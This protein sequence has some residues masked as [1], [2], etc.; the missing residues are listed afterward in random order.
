MFEAPDLMEKS[1]REVYHKKPPVLASIPIERKN[2]LER[3]LSVL[4]EVRPGEG[5]GVLLLTANIFVLLAGYYLLKTAREALIL[6]EGGAEVKTYSSAAQALLLWCVVPAY[7]AL[8]SRMGRLRVITAITLIFISNLL[9]FWYFGAQGKREGVV[10]F[11]WVGIFN[12][13]AVAQFWSFANDLFSEEQGKRLFPIIGIGSSTGALAGAEVASPFIKKAGPYPLMLAAAGALAVCLL[14]T[15]AIHRR[16]EK[17]PAQFSSGPA[18]KPLSRTNGL[19][20]ILRD[21]YLLLIAALIVLLNVVNTSGEFLLG[22]FVVAEAGRTMGPNLAAQQK[23]IGEF[24]GHFFSWVNL[25]GVLVQMFGVSRIFRHIGVRGSLYILPTIAAM[26]YC[27]LLFL[28]ILAVIRVGKILE[29]STD[30]SIMNTTRHA[31]FLPTSREAK[32][33]AKSAVDTFFPRSGDVLQ[34]GIVYAGTALAI[35]ISG[36]AIL[37]LV[38]TAAWLGVVV[39]LRR[40]HV[41]ASAAAVSA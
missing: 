23:F 16:V 26:N 13:F 22:K 41:R 27:L 37:N 38:L 36:F 31:L 21:R 39:A 6:S 18:D 19:Q 1:S 32:Y 20:L 14:L 25:V 10:F 2:P 40:Q 34:A 24:Y 9:L 4:A 8:T 33:K 17:H 28:P 29:N 5:M 15:Y 35:G 30:Y 11:I 3:A 12:N 7:A